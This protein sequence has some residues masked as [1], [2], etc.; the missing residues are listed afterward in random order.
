MRR[1]KSLKNTVLLVALINLLYFLVEFITAS[2][3]NSVSIFADS[4]D[5][6]E[7]TFINLLIFF[8]VSWT[9][10]KKK[11]VG[12]IL[13]ILILVP[14]I[15]ALW[16]VW[17]QIIDQKPT[18]SFALSS[19]GLGALITNCFCVFLLLQFKNY[20]GSL[21]KAAF[22][23]ARNDVVANIAIIITGILTFIYSSIWPD[24]LVGLFIAL[25]NANAS[26]EIYKITQ[27]EI[28]NNFI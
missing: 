15:S 8:A 28:K 1:E 21:A 25:I 13:V 16:A 12:M 11:I 10:Q 9:S 22:L 5:F 2:K 17:Q 24:I 7:D 19:I 3:I 27:Q 23:S 26:F 20:K 18:S 14:A 4:I 6:L